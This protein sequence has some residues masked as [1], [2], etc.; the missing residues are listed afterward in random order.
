MDC[1]EQLLCVV[2]SRRTATARGRHV[3]QRALEGRE[4]SVVDRREGE[5]GCEAEVAL[6][7]SEERLRLVQE[8]TGLAD[9]ESGTDGLLT[10]SERFFEQL[11]LPPATG[12]V[13]GKSW[14]GCIHPEDRDQL[15]EAIEAAIARHDEWFQAEFRIVR[16]DNGAAPPSVDPDKAASA[17]GLPICGRP[18]TR[19]GI[20]RAS[21][22][23]SCPC[24]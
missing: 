13:E 16:A 20:L 19:G 23:P 21:C 5:P 3:V 12:P 24:V 9:F 11:G 14:A 15:V 18:R 2:D 17:L 1:G 10:C 8:A 7:R 4:R 22:A 6:N